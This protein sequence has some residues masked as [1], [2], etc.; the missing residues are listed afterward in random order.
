[1]RYSTVSFYTTLTCCRNMTAIP[2][3]VRKS[4]SL[5]KWHFPWIIS[6]IIRKYR[7]F[8][9]NNFHILIQLKRIFAGRL[10]RAFSGPWLQYRLLISDG[11]T[12]SPILS[13]V[14]AARMKT[15]ITAS[16]RKI[17]KSLGRLTASR[18]FWFTTRCSRTKELCPVP[19]GS[20]S[21]RKG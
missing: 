12:D 13:G 19:T 9:A 15:F 8:L 7:N 16:S 6:R 5:A 21:W 14:G 20:T 4:E 10:A 11:S 1:M 2:T 18:P 17:W 3:P